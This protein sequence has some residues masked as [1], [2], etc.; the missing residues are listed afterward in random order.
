MR[1]TFR[2][3]FYINRSK[4]RN[5]EVPIFGR[6]TINGTM[7][8]FSCKCSVPEK[9]WSVQFNCA[10]GKSDV[11]R[12]VNLVLGGF[13]SQIYLSYQKFVITE[14]V[15]TARMIKE[16]ILKSGN[17]YKTLLASI[18]REIK[19]FG[20]RVGKDRADKT[21]KKMTAVRKHIKEFIS[22]NYKTADIF[23]Q[24]TDQEFIQSFSRYI[25]F[26][27]G[28]AQSTA[29]VYCTFLKK[30]LIQE[31]NN[32]NLR[33]N[34]FQ[35]IKL[36]ANVK[37]KQFLTEEE[38]LRMMQCKMEM[39]GMEMIKEMFIFC[40][41]T[42]L[43]FIDLKNLKRDSIITV[44]GE[45]WIMSQRQKNNMPY[46]VKLLK[47]PL[48]ILNRYSAKGNENIFELPSY[49]NVN[50]KIKI[51]GKVCGINKKIT[52]HIAR[53]TFATLAL[54]KGMPIESVSKIL[55]HSNITT[56]Q[57]YAKVINAKLESDFTLL[58]KK[59]EFLFK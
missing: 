24:E 20:E 31:Y 40:C 35:G 8:Q 22:H 26:D 9:L 30:I 23:L 56:T 45:H 50:K 52:F 27:K 21:Y 53:H 37:E 44:N 34:P 33:K 46:K 15:I 11:A 32:G 1:S 54:S 29:W 58:E 25:Q 28:L 18:D 59:L 7:A 3:L 42:G 10:T 38:I 13:R 17:D 49:E 14:P 57:I 2:I 5:G 12:R 47:Y 16:D 39:P 36:S 6:I 19:I 48:D 51:V 43:S 4:E 41:F 55:G